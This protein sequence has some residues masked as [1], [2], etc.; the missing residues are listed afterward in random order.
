MPGF[1]ELV[2]IAFVAIVVFG[3]DKLP[4]LA[5]QAGQL[6]RKGCNNA[7]GGFERVV[8]KIFSLPVEKR[9]EFKSSTL[10]LIHI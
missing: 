6:I 7:R 5:K 9:E 4:D 8:D 2:V 10:S 1:L 3:P